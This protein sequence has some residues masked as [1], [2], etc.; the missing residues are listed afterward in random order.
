[1]PIHDWS[2]VRPGLFHDFHQAWTVSLSSTLNRSVLPPGYFAEPHIH[3]GPRVEIDA[4][5]GLH[6]DGAG[7]FTPRL[8]KD[9]T[10]STVDFGTLSD[11][12]SVFVKLELQQVP[13]GIAG[14]CTASFGLYH[15]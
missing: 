5:I 8:T 12:A 6:I 15:T 14:T 1:M 4:A 9:Y 2:K 3:F 7:T 13:K 11:G 10:E